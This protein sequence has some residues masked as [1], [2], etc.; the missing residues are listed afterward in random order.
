MYKDWELSNTH[1]VKPRPLEKFHAGMVITF[2]SLNP[3]SKL[4]KLYNQQDSKLLTSIKIYFLRGLPTHWAININLTPQQYHKA[5]ANQILWRYMHL[6]AI[7][8]QEIHKY[9]MPIYKLTNKC[10][11]PTK[12]LEDSVGSKWVPLITKP[13]LM[14]KQTLTVL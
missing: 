13:K 5:P 1:Q 11:P 9:Q 14:F 2:R 10:L 3:K 12:Q 7:D 4:H 6:Q 8:R